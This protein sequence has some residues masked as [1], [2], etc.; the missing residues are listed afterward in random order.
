MYTYIYIHIYIYVGYHG[1][2]AMDSMSSGWSSES[3]AAASARRILTN[4]VTG[5]RQ[6]RL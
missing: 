5:D 3:F 1:R 6:G 2:T 4:N